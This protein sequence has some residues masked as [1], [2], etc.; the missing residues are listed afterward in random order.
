[1]S[2]IDW[3]NPRVLVTTLYRDILL[4]HADTGRRI[5]TCEVHAVITHLNWSPDRTFLA[6]ASQDDTVRLWSAS[7][8]PLALLLLPDLITLHW[9]SERTL[10]ATTHDNRSLHWDLP[11][12]L[13]TL[14]A[15]AETQQP[16]PL[17]AAE[18]RRFGLPVSDNTESE[19]RVPSD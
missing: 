10:T 15:L 18:R 11:Q 3:S 16:K 13:Q 19:Q 5:A 17:T 8:E 14:I 4:H 6:S 1:M 7:G 2:T 9:S 12:D